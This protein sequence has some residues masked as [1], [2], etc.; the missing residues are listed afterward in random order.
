MADETF[1]GGALRVAY[2]ET[3]EAP[4]DLTR[5]R[6]RT[7]GTD[8]AALDDPAALIVDAL[9]DQQFTLVRPLELTSTPASGGTRG[10]AQPATW[11]VD[12]DV[13]GTVT[14]V[15]VGDLGGFVG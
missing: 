2:P 11:A 8:R 3:F 12:L 15:S 9:G 4:R 5:D 13:D 14:L 6:P 10:L 7:L 1:D